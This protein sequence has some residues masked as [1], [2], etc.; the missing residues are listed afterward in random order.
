MEPTAKFQKSTNF[1]RTW[2]PDKRA[3]KTQLEKVARQLFGEEGHLQVGKRLRPNARKPANCMC[4]W[5]VCM[6]TTL[7]HRPSVNFR[8]MFV[9]MSVCVNDYQVCMHVCILSKETCFGYTY[10]HTHILSK[11]TCFDTTMYIH[12]CI[13]TYIRTYVHTHVCMHVCILRKPV[14][15]I[16]TYIYTYIM[17]H[18]YIHTYTRMYACM[19][20]EQGN[21]FPL[22]MHTYIHTYIHT[23]THTHTHI[24]G[25]ET[26]F[27]HA[28][29][30]I[31]IHTY[32]RAY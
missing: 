21:L 15:V 32:I 5:C 18:T 30:H 25:K 19:Y 17:I 10:T 7:N 13:Y 31:Y 1:S 24:M 9:H 14:S 20:I 3:T 28:Y 11:E 16:H 29:I 23:H 12:T 22:Y 2:S 26:Y 8:P 27:G 4:V 6:Y